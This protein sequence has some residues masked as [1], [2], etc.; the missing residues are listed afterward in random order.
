MKRYNPA[1]SLVEDDEAYGA[2]PTGFPPPTEVGPGDLLVRSPIIPDETDPGRVTGYRP[3]APLSPPL[4]TET[5][6]PGIAPLAPPGAAGSATGPV[7]QAPRGPAGLQ[8][9]GVTS[10]T[11]APT[12]ERQVKSAETAVSEGKLATAVEKTAAA[13]DDLTKARVAEQEAVARHKQALVKS[14]DQEAADRAAAETATN[15]AIADSISKSDDAKAKMVETQKAGERSLF[16]D[17]STLG[18]V[19]AT[20]LVGVS[21]AMQGYRGREGPSS[22]LQMWRAQEAADQAR[23]LRNY[24]QSKEYVALTKQDVQAARQAKLE[25]LAD[26]KNQSLARTEVLMRT[27]D[28]EVAPLKIPQLQAEAEKLKAGLAEDA[29]KDEIARN[30]L[31]EQ[32]QRSGGTVTTVVKK[33]PEG[34]EG[35]KALPLADKTD[36]DYKIGHEDAAKNTGELKELV[37]KSPKAFEVG[38]AAQQFWA[39]RNEFRKDMKFLGFPVGQ[40]IQNANLK[41]KIPQSEREAMEVIAR[42]AGVDPKTVVEIAAKK[43][44]LNSAIAKGYGGV[45]NPADRETAG[46]EMGDLTRDAKAYAEGL[47]RQENLFEARAGGIKKLRRFNDET[48]EAPPPLTQREAARLLTEAEKL[49]PRDPRRREIMAR[50]QA[51]AAGR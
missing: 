38:Q 46:A 36:L 10:T 22:G 44:S 4:V 13:T 31:H 21:E 30:Q 47:G 9:E 39:Q 20:L 41:G 2:R 15:L 35:G 23:K 45:I 16:E 7:P 37:R 5:P 50:V 12:T 48:P 18:K 1:T 40:I 43:T 24:E 34:P 14:A 42:G 26:I 51:A 19:V 3:A 11:T 33:A 28:A 29:A 8:V 25:K 17:K 49:D 27:L 6:V 32:H